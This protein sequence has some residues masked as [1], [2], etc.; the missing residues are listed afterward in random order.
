MKYKLVIFDLDGTILDTLEDLYNSVNF[1][2]C[3]NNLPE[4][5]IVEV[6]S[7]VGNGIRLLIERAVPENTAPK[8]VDIIFSDFKSH[9]R[10][11]S[12]DNT[13][14]YPGIIDLLVEL[15][16]SGIK[17]AVVSNKADFAVQELIKQ[18][19]DG[20]FDFAVGE[21]EN[22]AKKPNPDSVYEAL[23]FLDINKEEAVYIGDSE[24]DIETA[25]N[26]GLDEIIVD[27]GFR[28]TD[29]LHKCGAKLIFSEPDK[30]LKYLL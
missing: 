14:P 11:H 12:I 9:Y 1:A 19:F 22:I 16:K 21:R 29:F 26:S 15:R 2:L 20:L 24:V 13:E 6:R 3:K 23:R 28:D 8:T 30:L 5:S 4:R 10:N 27:W 17:T 18:Y 25:R 7:F